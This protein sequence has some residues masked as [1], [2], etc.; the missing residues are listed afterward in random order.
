MR[1]QPRDGELLEGLYIHDG[2]LTEDQI[3]EIFF[4]DATLR[5]TRVRIEKLLDSGY[6]AQL[7]RRERAKYAFRPLFLGVQGIEYVAARRGITP[8]ELKPRKPGDRESLI[9]HDVISN[10]FR[11]RMEKAIAAHPDFDLLEWIPSSV[12]WAKPDKITFTANRDGKSSQERRGIRPDGFALI[13]LHG[14]I[15]RPVRFP[16][17][18]DLSTEPHPRLAVEKFQAGVAYISSQEYRARFGDNKGRWLIIGESATRIRNMQHTAQRVIGRHAAAFYFTTL[19]M[20]EQ[21]NVLTDPIWFQG[22]DTTPKPL[23]QYIKVGA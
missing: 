1:F 23:E 5:A 4:P 15:E 8:K 20:T 10:W 11:I 9:P 12:F 22:A 7:E 6:L 14:D 17:E 19:E 16:I 21:Q 13:S 2:I 3:R 18:V